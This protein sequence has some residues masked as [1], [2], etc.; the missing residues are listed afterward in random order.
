MNFYHE[1]QLFP[2]K[3]EQLPGECVCVQEVYRLTQKDRAECTKIV[4]HFILIVNTGTQ[5]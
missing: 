5:N 3:P 4:E 1:S 2:F